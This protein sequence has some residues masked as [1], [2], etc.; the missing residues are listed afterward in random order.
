MNRS[1]LVAGM[2]LRA[3]GFESVAAIE[4]IRRHRPGALSNLTFVRLVEDWQCPA[5]AGP[6]AVG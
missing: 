6:V 2:L 1:G 4:L 5:P 3:L